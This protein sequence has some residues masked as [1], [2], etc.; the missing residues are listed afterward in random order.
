MVEPLIQDLAE[1]AARVSQAERLLLFLDFDGT[2]APIVEQPAMARLLPGTRQILLALTLSPNVSVAV[3]SGRALADLRKL[4]GLEGVVYVGNHGLEISG[5]GLQFLEPTAVAQQELLR[6]LAADLSTRLGTVEGAEV[7]YKGLTISVHFR[8]VAPARL[9]RVRRMVRAA[10]APLAGHFGIRVGKKVYEICP[11]SG[12]NKGNAVRWIRSQIGYSN[13]LE[14]YIGD[15]ITDEDA[16]ESLGDGITVKVGEPGATSA[17]YSLA[18]P[19]DVR[20]F[21]SWLVDVTCCVPGAAP[22]EVGQ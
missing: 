15:D 14:I 11:E 7:E 19:A 18:D 6:N 5:P 20:H 12:W 13:T 17:R 8:R 22:L 4:V 1:I 16:F 2:L 21:L 10:L 3:I 9:N